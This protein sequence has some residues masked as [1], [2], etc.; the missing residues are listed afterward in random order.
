MNESNSFFS[1]IKYAL[2]GLGITFL[3]MGLFDGYGLYK[4]GYNRAIE[5]ANFQ[6]TIIALVAGSLCLVASIIMHKIKSNPE[7]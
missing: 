4:M 3:S 5:Q 6:E 7:K 1:N 2:L